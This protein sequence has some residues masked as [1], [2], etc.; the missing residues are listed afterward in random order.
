M[1]S[2]TLLKSLIVIL[3]SVFASAQG[4]GGKAGLGGKAGFGGGASAGG[5]TPS[6]ISGLRAWYAADSGLTCTGGCSSGNP[7][8]VWADKS[9]NANNLTGVNGPTFQSA[10]VN[11]LPAVK[12][13]AAS[14]QGFTFGTPVNLQTA[15]TIF[16][17]VK[18]TTVAQGILVGGDGDALGYWVG[19]ASNE[20][21]S[22]WIGNAQITHGNVAGDTSWHQINSTYDNSTAALRLGSASDPCGAGPGT[23]TCSITA[24]AIIANETT[25]GYKTYPSASQYLDGYIAEII[26]Y[27]RV[28]T[29]GEITT[30]ETYLTGRYAL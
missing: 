24:K 15:S 19:A 12:F 4:V 8:T 22:D 18:M 5:G 14:T 30:V 11:G 25:I 26:I 17:V 13:T 23:T 10:Q 16:V 2:R 1:L 3:L 28:L 21:G 7:V 9:T 27:N 29:G 20:Q 6:S